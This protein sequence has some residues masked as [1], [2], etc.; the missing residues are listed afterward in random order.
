[1]KKE[2]KTAR[3]TC[4]QKTFET[5]IPFLGGA[6]LPSENAI[7]TQQTIGD[8]QIATGRLCSSS[9]ITTPFMC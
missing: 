8:Q 1:M 3:R 6:T 9:F 4:A 5:L 7:R 2:G